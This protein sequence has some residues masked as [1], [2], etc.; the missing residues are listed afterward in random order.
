MKGLAIQNV[1]NAFVAKFNWMMANHAQATGDDA[2]ALYTSPKTYGI[3]GQ[4]GSD[5]E[6]IL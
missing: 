6:R 1:A 2:N 5:F 3:L 4:N